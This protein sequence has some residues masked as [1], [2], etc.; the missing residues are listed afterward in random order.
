[1]QHSPQLSKDQLIGITQYTPA[2]LGPPLAVGIMAMSGDELAKEDV[3]GKAV[4]LIHA[5]KDHLWTMGKNRGAPPPDPSPWT[6]DQDKDKAEAE[7]QALG[8]S[9]DI[10]EAAG[11]G[12]TNSAADDT[13]PEV[14]ISDNKVQLSPEGSFKWIS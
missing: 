13:T 9:D 14:P 7:D 8:T 1:V 10:G 4:L 11:S 3:S 6:G 12:Q 5:W 2:G